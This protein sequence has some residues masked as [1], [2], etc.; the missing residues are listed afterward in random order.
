MA[1]D[2]DR[3][4]LRKFITKEI[5][6]WKEDTESTR[7]DEIEKQ[8]KEMSSFS[9]SALS[10]DTSTFREFTE[11]LK[12]VQLQTE[13]LRVEVGSYQTVLHGLKN[14]V[15]NFAHITASDER[16]GE[17]AQRPSHNSVLKEAIKAADNDRN[18]GAGS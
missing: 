15:R 17:V 5:S 1:L 18:G 4:I 11:L 3:R 7:L 8:Q 2:E 14:N 13:A 10:V 6:E 12:T 9:G 16:H